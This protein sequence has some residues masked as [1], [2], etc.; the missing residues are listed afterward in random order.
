MS[1]QL[2]P[3]SGAPCAR[4][5]AQ[6]GAVLV[7]L[8]WGLTF[9]LI[10]IG[11][12]DLHPLYFVTLRFLLATLGFVPVLILFR[13]PLSALRQALVPGLFTGGL[14]SLIYLFQ[15]TGLVTVSA[16][17]AA[18]ITAS[19][20]IFTPLISPLFGRGWPKRLD[21]ATAL[22]AI[23]GLF[24]IMDPGKGPVT[25]GDLWI[26][27]C[28]L[29]LAVSLQ[30]LAILMAR[31]YD[32]RAL[33]FWQLTG[34]LTISA[35][36]LGVME[37][38]KFAPT[39]TAWI[40]IGICAWGVTIGTFLLQ[41]WCQR[42]ISPERAALIYCLEPVF[43]VLFGFL[44]LSE[45]LSLQ[46]LIGGLL[47]VVAIGTERFLALS[48]QVVRQVRIRLRAAAVKKVAGPSCPL[49]K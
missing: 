28:A 9:P 5:T 26:L 39:P 18:F 33:V 4:R 12:S 17:R 48:S 38:P 13:V 27:L 2:P 36:G 20:V 19:Y 45:T 6:W 24:L 1:S 29:I 31:A 32:L 30:V 10:R 35:M 34:V 22:L 3:T 7:T 14:F 49:A 42:F 47:I 21:L 25:R 41:A 46:G 16:P 43:A 8:L 44:M 23:F 37:V 15:T 11:V 40:A